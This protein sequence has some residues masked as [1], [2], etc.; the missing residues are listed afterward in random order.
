MNGNL[1]ACV[2]LTPCSM[3][4]LKS[5]ITFTYANCKSYLSGCTVNK[6]NDNCEEITTCT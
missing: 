6:S 2:D 4:A 3:A 1:T 5:N